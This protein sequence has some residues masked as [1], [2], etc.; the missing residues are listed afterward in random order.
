VG[1]KKITA[2][3]DGYVGVERQKT[4]DDPVRYTEGVVI[5]SA[6]GGRVPLMTKDEILW[7]I[8]DLQEGLDQ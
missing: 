6:L 8:Q 5:V 1:V 7:L 3:P 4:S 2:H